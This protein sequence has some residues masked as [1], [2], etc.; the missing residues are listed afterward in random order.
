MT[1]NEQL[2]ARA[3]GKEEAWEALG[4]RAA[5]RLY[6]ELADALEAT[7]RERD[8]AEAKLAKIREWVE[9]AGVTFGGRHAMPTAN[10]NALRA[11]LDA[12]PTP[13][14]PLMDKAND[15]A[16]AATPPEERQECAEKIADRLAQKRPTIPEVCNAISARIASAKPAPVEAGEHICGFNLPSGRIIPPSECAE[17]ADEKAEAGERERAHFHLTPLYRAPQ[18]AKPIEVTDAMVRAGALA[19]CALSSQL[20]MAGAR[21]LARAAIEAALKEMGK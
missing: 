20:S 8:E 1:N 16:L 15:D 13:E 4:G 11:L 2:I 17:C 9:A 19:M 12:D 18:P 5:A 3:R 7:T 10:L 21:D 14:T 6:A